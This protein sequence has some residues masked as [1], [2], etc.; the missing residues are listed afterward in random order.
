[1]KILIVGGVADGASANRAAMS[2]NDLCYAPP[3]NSAKNIL[4]T[5]PVFTICQ[6][7][8]TSYFAA[9]ILQQNGFDAHSI[10]GGAHLNL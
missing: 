3:F 10:I 1:L 9:R 7:G 6:M 4:L 8:K 2:M 5:Q